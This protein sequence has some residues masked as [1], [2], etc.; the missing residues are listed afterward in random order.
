[1][2]KL[3]G[4]AMGVLAMSFAVVGAMAVSVSVR[5]QSTDIDPLEDFRT[6]DDS[7][8]PFEG[9]GNEA[10]SSIFDIIHQMQLRN[11]GSLEDF[12]RQRTENIET[13]ADRFRQQ[14]LLRL[15]NQSTP[16]VED[17]SLPPEP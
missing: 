9:S 14:R 16:I 3:N 12:N 4:L 7:P 1:M 5:A 8:N 15:E 10:Q 6:T 2:S 17:G 11:G 13:E